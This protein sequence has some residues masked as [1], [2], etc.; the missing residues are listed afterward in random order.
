VIENIEVLRQSSRQWFHYAFV[1]DQEELAAKRLNQVSVRL[2]AA[3]PTQVSGVILR[4]HKALCVK[5]F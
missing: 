4:F 3:T 1:D 2:P 5:E